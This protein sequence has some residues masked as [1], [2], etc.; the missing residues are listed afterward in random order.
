MEIIKKLDEKFEETLCAILLSAMT[1]IISIQIV[2]RQLGTPAAWSEELARYMFVWLI[3]VGCSLGVKRRKHIK[4]DAV[5]LL[6]KEEWHIVMYIISNILFMVFC[7][8]I[9]YY[10][11]ELLYK[12]QFVQKQLSPAMRIPM[13]IPYSSFVFGCLLMIIRLIQDTIKLIREKRGDH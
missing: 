2:F 6:I 12:I 13:V 8:L 9:S 7:I 4:V 11:I 5:M 1:V 3:Y 10:G